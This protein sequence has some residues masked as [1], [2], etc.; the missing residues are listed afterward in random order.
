MLAALSVVGGWIQFAGL[1]HPLS[2]FLAPVAEPLVEPTGTQDLVTS[3]LAVG[4]GLAGM[5]I[6]WQLYGVRRAQL[7]EARFWR[8]LLEHKLYFDEAYDALFYRP[9]NRLALF[10]GRTVE[11]PIVLGSAGGIADGVRALGHRLAAVQTGI[12]RSYA[13]LVTLAAAVIVLVFILVR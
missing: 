12:L 6:A 13:I 7:P 2:D 3:I 10:L 9:A 8:R 4:M 11:A 5:L 1:W